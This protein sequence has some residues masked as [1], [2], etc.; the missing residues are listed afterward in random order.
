M[1]NFNS[2]GILDYD[3]DR[4]FH[5]STSTSFRGGGPGCHR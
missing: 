1:A 3:G 2:N 4:W 5:L